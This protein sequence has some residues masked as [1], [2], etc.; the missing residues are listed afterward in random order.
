M[1]VEKASNTLPPLPVAVSKLLEPIPI[2]VL[3]PNLSA[4][5]Q[6]PSPRRGRPPRKKD[7]DPSR[8]K[9]S[10]GR[11]GKSNM[12]ISS[13][14]PPEEPVEVNKP[15][16]S[17]SIKLRIFKDK[18]TSKFVSISDTY[19]LPLPLV[20]EIENNVLEAPVVAKKRGRPKSKKRIEVEAE[21]E[22][23]STKVIIKL[24]KPKHK[25][26]QL[27]TD[28]VTRNSRR[29]RNSDSG[30]EPLMPVL[31]VAAAEES[32]AYNYNRR[33][34]RESPSSDL[35]SA[36]PPNITSREL[37][38]PVKALELVERLQEDDLEFREMS[39]VLS[40]MEGAGAE[41][42]SGLE[43]DKSLSPANENPPEPF[44]TT[45]YYSRSPDPAPA[46]VALPPTS[47]PCHQDPP[48][49]FRSILE[50]EWDESYDEESPKKS[51]LSPSKVTRFDMPEFVRPKADTEIS[52]HQNQHAEV[53]VGQ[54]ASISI[55]PASKPFNAPYAVRNLLSEFTEKHEHGTDGESDEQGKAELV[56]GHELEPPP[57]PQQYE[58]P[59]KLLAKSDQ[60]SGSG[61]GPVTSRKVSIF[62]SRNTTTTAA[63]GS[64]VSPKKRLALYK[65]K[66]AGQD[67]V[68]RSA[69]AVLGLHSPN[70]LFDEDEDGDGDGPIQLR[71][72]LRTAEKDRFGNEIPADG[73]KVTCTQGT[74]KLFTVIKNVKPIHELQESG[75][76]HEFDGDIW[77][78]LSDLK[79]SNPLSSR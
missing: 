16:T 2:P 71:R 47:E 12:S 70:N 64:T 22:S 66:F 15:L 25:E 75:E 10:V 14:S 31:S 35:F 39:A 17:P 73:T 28:R 37:P 76:V 55:G 62:K 42:E 3:P 6:T 65:H 44:P 74:K 18:A 11:K 48:R 38:L 19:A 8:P 61:S 58:Y 21:A 36:S 23:K 1:E 53:Q 24:K 67:T 40:S 4:P 32:G 13:S 34:S 68:D 20:Q 33:A 72:V 79:D 41:V 29:Q 7:A 52:D 77:Y 27:T 50:D 30:G 59:E 78:I 5:Q 43:L 45:N 26:S 60:S 56:K 51:G 63:V 69:E 46:A 9:N 49:D 57:Y 54:E